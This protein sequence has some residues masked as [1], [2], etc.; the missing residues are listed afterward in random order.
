MIDRF[1]SVYTFM[2]NE[3]LELDHNIIEKE[4]FYKYIISLFNPIYNENTLSKK[5]SIYDFTKKMV[6]KKHHD[7]KIFF[8]I[9]NPELI[10]DNLLNLENSDNFKK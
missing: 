5:K 2:F 6:N 10:L 4:S 1:K 3:D 8:N 9:E 7:L